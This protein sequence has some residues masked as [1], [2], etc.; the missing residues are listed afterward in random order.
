MFSRKWKSLRNFSKESSPKLNQDTFNLLL[1]LSQTLKLFP[2][3]SFLRSFQV[4]WFCQSRD[5]LNILES[6]TSVLSGITWQEM[7]IALFWVF[8]S[9]IAFPIFT[10]I[11]LK[12]ARVISGS[13]QRIIRQR[14]G[15]V[16]F[17]QPLHPHLSQTYNIFTLICWIF[18]SCVTLRI[19]YHSALFMF[20]F[21][22]LL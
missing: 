18:Y 17:F 20:S 1:D 7:I 4:L 6:S 19:R 22:F 21:H 10:I 14:S 8:L 16:D 11:W 2:P 13:R 12:P 3:L 9:E 15:W 5:G